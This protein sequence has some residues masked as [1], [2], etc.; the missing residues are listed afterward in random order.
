[1]KKAPLKIACLSSAIVLCLMS[2]SPAEATNK[3]SS[4]DVTKGRL[5]FEYRGGYDFDGDS[6]KNGIDQHKFG[7]NYGV[8]DRFR[9]EVKADLASNGTER[10]WT[11]IEW[12]N[13]FQLIKDGSFWPKLSVQENYKFSLLDAKADKLE[14]TFL[15]GKD[16]GSFTH[17]ANLN[18]ENEVGPKAR[19]GT[20]INLG[21]KTKYRYQPALEPGFEF[22]ADFGKVIGPVTPGQKKYQIGPVLYGTVAKNVKY[23]FGVL[24]GLSE[25]APDTRLKAIITYGF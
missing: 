24:I 4:P 18:F 14:G 8:T 21:W 2:A 11:F 20:D 17:V 7:V 12:S 19:S 6:R 13:R 3:V 10:D 16:A 25:I 22:Y 9:T 5:E 15:L 1:M 23:E